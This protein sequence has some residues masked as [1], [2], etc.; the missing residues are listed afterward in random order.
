MPR[1]DQATIDLWPA[2]VLVGAAAAALIPNGL[3]LRRRSRSW[4]E[5]VFNA[6]CFALLVGAA[7]GWWRADGTGA[8][9]FAAEV[10][11]L[12]VVLWCSGLGRFD[13]VARGH[14][15][16]AGAGVA[17][18]LANR[19]PSVLV[20]GFTL[21]LLPSVRMS[22]A[23]VE[24]R[25][26]ARAALPLVL[27]VLGTALLATDGL[28]TAPDHR[29]ATTNNLAAHRAALGT[30][31]LIFGLFSSLL[32]ALVVH[33]SSA[34][35]SPPSPPSIALTC[36]AGCVFLNQCVSPLAAT[37]FAVAQALAAIAWV[38]A[39][40]L[41]PLGVLVGLGATSRPGLLSALVAV[42]LG[43]TVVGFHVASMHST[44]YGSVAVVQL[45]LF[46]VGVS[47]FDAMK[48]AE[49]ARPARPWL[50]S[51]LAIALVGLP[52]TF[53]FWTRCLLLKSA[54]IGG[55][56][57]DH[58]VLAWL[59]ALAFVGELL[60]I[61]RLLQSPETARQ[62]G[63][64]FSLIYLA[65]PLLAVA[66]LAA[67]LAPQ[68]ILTAANRVVEQPRLGER[69]IARRPVGAEGLLMVVTSPARPQAVVAQTIPV[70]AS[71]RRQEEPSPP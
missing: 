69:L 1:W 54:L 33:A 31:I 32:P 50:W 12:G 52:P 5:T 41:L 61:G 46:L 64:R 24:Y 4:S 21:V 40:T 56:S 71:T 67:G 58:T 3:G 36:F 11:L 43:Q 2:L 19:E 30:L 45:L 68:P 57:A 9:A 26:W 49:A 10:G 35:R 39:A 8:T 17:L 27:V 22:S 53:G 62:A 42:Q 34:A 66:T 65:V 44:S 29:V 48:D 7:I 15:L 6:A 25:T 70:A 60:L 59:S 55:A 16:L 51:I 63:R 18:M 23:T 28:P 37:T 20:I 38:M 14:H 13:A 47:L